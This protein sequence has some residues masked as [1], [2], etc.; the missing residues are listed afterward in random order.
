MTSYGSSRT[1]GTVAG[2]QTNDTYPGMVNGNSKILP[3]LINEQS[4]SI[5]LTIQNPMYQNY[6]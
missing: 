6:H 5:P 2:Y 4:T 3:G 1:D